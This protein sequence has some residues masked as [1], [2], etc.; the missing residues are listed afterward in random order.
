VE[1]DRTLQLGRLERAS[2]YGAHE[3]SGGPIVKQLDAE[4]PMPPVEALGRG[5]VR[6]IWLDLKGGHAVR[7]RAYRSITRWLDPPPP[8]HRRDGTF[9]S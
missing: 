9:T 7:V 6:Q 3:N 8:S 5:D 1:Q 4:L 2:L